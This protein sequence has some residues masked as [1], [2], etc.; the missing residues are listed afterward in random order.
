MYKRNSF[1]K[2]LV[3]MN[4]IAKS[5]SVTNFGRPDGGLYFHPLLKANVILFPRLSPRGALSINSAKGSNNLF[6]EIK[7]IAELYSLSSNTPSLSSEDNLDGV[8]WEV[9]WA[10]LKSNKKS[11]FSFKT[12]RR[13]PCLHANRT[14]WSTMSV[15]PSI[16]P[17]WFKYW[18][19]SLTR[20]LSIIKSLACSNSDFFWGRAVVYISLKTSAAIFAL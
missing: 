4:C 3:W 16:E 1:R 7:S 8:G 17:L 13:K 12:E 5:Y 20:L 19:N 2:L 9:S 6:L 10:V 18:F 11:P 15:K 14:V